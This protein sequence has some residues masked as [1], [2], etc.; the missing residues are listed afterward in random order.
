MASCVLARHHL[1][2]VPQTAVHWQN[3][4]ADNGRSFRR[5]LLAYRDGARLHAGTR[6]NAMQLE[7]IV[8]KLD[9]LVRAGVPEQEAAMAL[10]SIG[11]FTVGCVLEEQA[12]SDHANQELEK[13]LR[14]GGLSGPAL[15]VASIVENGSG[16]TAF[17]FGMSLMLDGLERRVKRMRKSG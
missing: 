12:S 7:R 6:P 5:A 1:H 10:Y 17:E 13:T 4:L 11:Q 8:A 3:W 16:E 15:H 14:E 2:E 9:Y